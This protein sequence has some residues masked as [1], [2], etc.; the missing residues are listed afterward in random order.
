ML[1]HTLSV[2]DATGVDGMTHCRLLNAFRCSLAA[3][4]W[5]LAF[6]P[7]SPCS[8]APSH[9]PS[10]GWCSLVLCVATV[11]TIASIA[12][13]PAIAAIAAI[14][15]TALRPSPPLP[16]SPPNL[17]HCPFAAHHPS[18][19]HLCRHTRKDDDLRPLKDDDL[20]PRTR[21]DV[22]HV[23]VHGHGTV[24]APH[25]TCTKLLYRQITNGPAPFMN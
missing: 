4:G 3:D 2:M 15:T 5:L 10:F 22:E 20:P 8:G 9:L 25:L 13:S 16:P 7:L 17:R 1:T 11:A 14:A 21:T 24:D 6:C 23:H 19:P 12:T 18:P